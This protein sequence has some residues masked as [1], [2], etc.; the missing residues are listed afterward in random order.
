MTKLPVDVRAGDCLSPRTWQL[1]KNRYDVM[2]KKEPNFPAPNSYEMLRQMT[3]NWSWSDIC[4]ENMEVV[5]LNKTKNYL[6]KNKY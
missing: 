6:H 1:S 5:Q 4:L 2:V 3:I